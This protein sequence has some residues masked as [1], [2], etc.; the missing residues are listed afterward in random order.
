MRDTK[1]LYTDTKNKLLKDNC[2]SLD[3]IALVSIEN[4]QRELF[5]ELYERAVSANNDI[6]IKF[7]EDN[8]KL[9]EKFDAI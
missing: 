7:L 9:I 8:E 6:V 2:Q 3:V 1:Q 5:S 4:A